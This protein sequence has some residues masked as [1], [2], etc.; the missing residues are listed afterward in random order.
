MRRTRYQLKNAFILIEHY[1]KSFNLI[2]QKYL[3]IL[4]D[5]E[6]DTSFCID[7]CEVEK[8]Y[9]NESM[10]TNTGVFYFLGFKGTI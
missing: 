2:F 5:T 1:K 6:I 3:I 7:L 4:V 8:Q 10:A 9:S